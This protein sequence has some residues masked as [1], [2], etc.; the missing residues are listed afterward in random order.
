MSAES[1]RWLSQD[2]IRRN[3]EFARSQYNSIEKD[4]RTCLRYVEFTK[5]HLDVYSFKLADLI[6]RIG[7]EILRSFELVLFNPKRKKTFFW[8]PNLEK[9]I[10]EIQR[11]KDRFHD[12]FIDYVNAFARARPRGLEIGVEVDYIDRCIVPFKTQKRINKKG[13]EVDIVF[14]WEDGYNALKHRV[15]KEFDKSA[16]LRHALFSL[17]GLWIL[18][19]CIDLDFGRRGLAKSNIFGRIIDRTSLPTKMEEL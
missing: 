2:I 1:I 12:R 6:I 17:A 4:F 3:V 7:P 15:V 9:T 19:Y 5:D 18:H 11:E 13:K 10:L 8:G 16:T 14:W